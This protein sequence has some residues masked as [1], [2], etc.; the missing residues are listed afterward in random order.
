[1]GSTPPESEHVHHHRSLS[2]NG[3]SWGA[4]YG[5]RPASPADMVPPYGCGTERATGCAGR[6]DLLASRNSPKTASADEA[7]KGRRQAETT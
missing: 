4:C 6:R 1:M 5:R 7:P 2:P 3:I